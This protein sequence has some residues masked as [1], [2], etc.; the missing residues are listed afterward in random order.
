MILSPTYHSPSQPT[1]RR[2]ISRISI[3]GTPELYPSI[4]WHE[5]YENIT[6]WASVVND[7][8]NMIAVAAGTNL[9]Q[10]LN[11][12]QC[13]VFFRPTAFAIAVNPLQQS[14]V[15]EAQP[16]VEA[17]DIEPTGHLRANVMHSINLLSRMSPSLYVSV[18]GETL[19][20]NV[21]RMQK[22]R[23]HLNLTEAVTSAVAESFTV[24]IDD[25]LVAYGASQ[26]SNAQDAT[27][28]A[29]RG[30]VEAVQVGQPLYRY[31]VFVQNFVII[32]IVGF[33]AT[34]TRG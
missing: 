23:P 34:R 22:Q 25:I 18:L 5:K 3:I 6:A 16:S 21:E 2:V 19:S 11:Q 20:R 4:S 9:Y 33:E 24:I 8:R 27:F 12:T 32:L 13:E 15:V 14:I 10:E 30:V 26:I 29:V 28:S 17:E 31:L 7:N 1:M